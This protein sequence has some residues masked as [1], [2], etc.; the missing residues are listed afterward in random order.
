MKL[1]NRSKSRL[2]VDIDSYRR[3]ATKKSKLKS[4][5]LA[6]FCLFMVPL[7]SHAEL[8]VE[9][10]HSPL[11]ANGFIQ[12]KTPYIT[13]LPFEIA[14]IMNLWLQYS[15]LGS[16]AG[17]HKVS[18]FE[19]LDGTEG[20]T[21]LNYKVLDKTSSILSLE[22]QGQY[23]GA[24]PSDETSR[25]T[26]NIGTGQPIRLLDILSRDGAIKLNQILID[27][28]ISEIKN[29]L[30][31]NKQRNSLE[32]NDEKSEFDVQ[33]EEYTKCEKMLA[34]ETLERVQFTITKNQLTIFRG[35]QFRHQIQA[36]DDLGE[37]P[38]TQTT[39]KIETF[40]NPY[41]KCLISNQGG[42]CK[43]EENSMYGVY[44]GVIASRPAT[45]ILGQG[46]FTP[47]FFFED[48]GAPI[49]LIGGELIPD[50]IQLKSESNEDNP[51]AQQTL[52]LK[53]EKSNIITGTWQLGDGSPLPIMLH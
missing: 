30:T 40:L 18:P 24:Y 23:M 52:N 14:N 9:E 2:T 41:G 33:L 39:A 7:D 12:Y 47:V 4:I 45:L 6:T 50:S 15:R 5:F 48:D 25:T 44:Q 20:L 43:P 46:D 32:Y 35:C 34:N 22:F 17:H 37:I 21:G 38:F 42:I 51:S 13:G 29:F 1:E 27:Y 16:I 11:E 26:L 49:K 19:K 31:K 10:L 53:I 36:L 3:R 8:T 28:Q